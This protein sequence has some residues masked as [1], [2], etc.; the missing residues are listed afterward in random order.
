MANFHYVYILVSESHPGRHYTGL[1]RDL[2]GRVKAHNS[3]QLPHTAK[4][5]P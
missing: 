2:Q 3:G 5:R 4:Y 1:T